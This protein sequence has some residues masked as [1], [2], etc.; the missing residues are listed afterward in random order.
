MPAEST[1]REWALADRSGFAAQYARARELQVHALAEEI[2]TI[3]DDVSRDQV[4]SVN[5]DGSV[6][7]ATNHEH[8]NRSR[9]RVDARKWYASK[10]MP[11]VYGERITQEHTG[12]N[13]SKLFDNMSTDEL[14]KHVA[15]EAEEFGLSVPSSATSNGSGKPH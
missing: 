5:E 9:L 3:A 8:I 15:R 11:K 13:G 2:L 14:R 4:K 7:E 10:I 12:A 6:S 1:V